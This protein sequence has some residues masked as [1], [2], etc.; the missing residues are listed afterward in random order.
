MWTSA[1]WKR[2]G[3]CSMR[4]VA[5]RLVTNPRQVHILIFEQRLRDSRTQKKK[6]R[7]SE[8]SSI[9]EDG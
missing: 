7:R 4:I 2:W 6:P 1:F 5:P 9:D 8:A 3:T